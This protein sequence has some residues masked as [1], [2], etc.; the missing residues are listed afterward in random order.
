MANE[1]TTDN[2]NTKAQEVA[3]IGDGD[4]VYIFKTGAQGFSR[5][6]A[7]HFAQGGNSNANKI[8]NIRDNKEYRL[9]VGSQNQLN[10]LRGVYESDVIYIVAEEVQGTTIPITGIS[11][12]CVKSSSAA[13]TYNLTATLSP[14]NTTQTSVLWRIKSGSSYASLSSNGLSATLTVLNGANN[15][16]VVVECYSAVDETVSHEVEQ[17]VTYEEPSVEVTITDITVSNTLAN[18]IKQCT[19]VFSDGSSYDVTWVSSDTSIAEIN[20]NGMLTIKATGTVTI[21]ASLSQDNSY[22]EEISVTYTDESVPVAGELDFTHSRTA[23]NTLTL[24]ATKDGSSVN[25][26]F[27]LS[28]S[29]PNVYQLQNGELVA[30]PAVSINGNT[31]T[32]HDDCTVTVVATSGGDT[33]AKSITIAHNT[34]D[35]IWFEDAN[36]KSALIAGGVSSGSEITYA[37]AD[38]VGASGAAV[39][40]LKF[41]AGNTSIQRFKELK[42]F[43]KCKYFGNGNNHKVYLNGCSNLKCIY[44]PDGGGMYEQGTNAFNGC[45]LSEVHISSIESLC[46]YSIA[47][48]L[49]SFSSAGK[50]ANGLGL[51]INGVEVKDIVVPDT[52]TTIKSYV[53]AGLN[54]IE[55][56]VINGGET[57][58]GYRLFDGCSSLESIVVG[59]NVSELPKGN[60]SDGP[61]AGLPSLATVVLGAGIETLY[62]NYFKDST[63]LTSLTL[64]YPG[65]E[66]KPIIP[67]V[68]AFYNSATTG[69]FLGTVNLYVPS[70]RK[71]AYSSDSGW[72]GA[73][74]INEISE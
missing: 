67:Y 26:S 74:S 69:T 21:T 55:S 22:S 43:T 24:A 10:A 4:F 48:L 41:L 57:S 1:I 40:N 11:V 72:S 38:N 59:D 66:Q 45:S 5:I 54:R 56:V 44:L 61:L 73:A 52:V 14:S 58:V 15:N 30:V 34:N 18:N 13:N 3:S 32:Y 17:A 27:A 2:I 47:S 31:L 12:S 53:F 63:N 49:A 64:K 42:Y 25:A 29:V 36:T 65:T 33:K 20:S 16:T 71:N 9:W 46:N 50:D 51:Y 60:L 7:S 23:A 6:A 70:S 28:G 19:P 37:Q 8:K 35:N 39:A 62:Q 68:S